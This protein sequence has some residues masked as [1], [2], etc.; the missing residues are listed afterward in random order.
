[1]AKVVIAN[2]NIQ[3]I[4]LLIS[5]RSLDE[6][7]KYNLTPEMF[8]NQ[9][10][11]MLKI[12]QFTEEYGETPV[13]DT[14]LDWDSEFYDCLDINDPEILARQLQ[15]DYFYTH[16]FNNMLNKCMNN[17]QLNPEESMREMAKFCMEH[18]D[19]IYGKV[20]SYKYQEQADEQVE[21]LHDMV[22]RK[23]IIIPTGFDALDR[24]IGGLRTIKELCV[25][26]ARMNQGK[27][28]VACKMAV[29]GMKSGRRV[30][31]YS[32][33]SPVEHV[34]YRLDTLLFGFPNRKLMLYDLSEED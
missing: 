7:K 34:N 16:D 33:E 32:G 2:A 5:E 27:S 29:E 4:N 31:Y 26:F 28:W 22:T 11:L 8:G 18:T 19:I 17:V 12:L 20:K 13:L 6:Y 23:D 14:V 3:M 15:V 21:V 25:V 9:K 1:M 24:E 30:L 10:E